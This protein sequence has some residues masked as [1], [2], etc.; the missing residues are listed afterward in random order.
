MLKTTLSMAG[1]R[2][3]PNLCCLCSLLCN[4]WD[5]ERPRSI[6]IRR[7][8]LASPSRARKMRGESFPPDFPPFHASLRA[9][10]AHGTT[11]GAIHV[12]EVPERRRSG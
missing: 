11:P 4:S 6:R 5:V 10:S 7:K 12:E 3:N 1:E 9:S 2:M 8:L